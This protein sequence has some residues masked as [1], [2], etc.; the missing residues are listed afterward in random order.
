MNGT[1]TQVSPEPKK[2]L[3]NGRDDF[4]ARITRALAERAGYMC[5]NP[6]CRRLTV[7]PHSAPERSTKIGEA[8]HIRAA[9]SGG[10]RFDDQQS[11]D[12]RRAVANG[13]WLCASCAALIDKDAAA[14]PVDTLEGW[15]REA[16][17]DILER[18]T[19]GVRALDIGAEAP[20]RRDRVEAN[21]LLDQAFDLLAGTEQSQRITWRDIDQ[22]SLERARRLIADAAT[23]DPSGP[24]LPILRAAYFCSLN[25]PEE[26][27]AELDRTPRRHITIEHRLMRA[28]CLYFAGRH[29]ESVEILADLSKEPVAPA[30]V[31]YNLGYAALE[32]DDPASAAPY[33]ERAVELDPDY[34]EAWDMWGSSL[35]KLRSDFPQVL[36][37]AQSAYVLRP[38]DV[39][40]VTNFATLLLDLNLVDDALALLSPLVNEHPADERILGVLGRAHAKLGDLHLAEDVL[41]RSVLVAPGEPIRLSNLAEVLARRGKRAESL[42]M[43]RRALAAHHPDPET[44]HARVQ[45][46]EMG[47]AA[48]EEETSRPSSDTVA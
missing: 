18:L 27:L 1:Q 5:S 38:R 3:A 32:A 37:C 44:L 2:G 47:E 41:R 16:E 6:S 9:S 45:A 12:Q 33:F 25:F 35:Y 28:K 14:Y 21:R 40:A 7:G 8:A 24:R 19:N 46:L 43:F 23:Y 20:T 15:K 39:N 42:V 29:D 31:F 22:P 26:A 48:R 4:P 11:A 34:F 36:A 10:P 30:S 17:N 13:I